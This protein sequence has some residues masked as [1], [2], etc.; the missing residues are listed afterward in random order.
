MVSNGAP[1]ELEVYQRMLDRERAARREAERLIEEKSRELYEANHCLA[2]ALATQRRES[3]YQRVVL[4]SVADGILTIGS[5]GRVQTA[6][7]SICRIFACPQDMMIGR[8]VEELLSLEANNELPTLENHFF[9]DR[10]T[11]KQ[12][13]VNA[14]GRSLQGDRLSLELSASYATFDDDV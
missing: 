6:N 13:M 8:D 3:Y 4:D 12:P 9:A 5:E 1:A 11:D 7:P 2:D 10:C 14:V